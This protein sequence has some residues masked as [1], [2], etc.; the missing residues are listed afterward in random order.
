MDLYEEEFSD[1]RCD[2]WRVMIGATGASD[3][4]ACSFAI[5]LPL[6]E[7]VLVN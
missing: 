3:L 1:R 4:D 7:C 2:G 6:D 5:L